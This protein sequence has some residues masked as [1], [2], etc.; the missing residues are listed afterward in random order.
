MHRY[1]R[2]ELSPS[3]DV[4]LGVPAGINADGKISGTRVLNCPPVSCGG[5]HEAI[6]AWTNSSIFADMPI[7]AAE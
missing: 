3:P 1:L 4:R 5:R 7:R 6:D 2:P